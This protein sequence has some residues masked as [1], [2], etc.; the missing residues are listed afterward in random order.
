MKEIASDEMPK[1][2]KEGA[3]EMLKA[4]DLISTFIE[5]LKKSLK[6]DELDEVGSAI[7]KVMAIKCCLN[8]YPTHRE[9]IVKDFEKQGLIKILN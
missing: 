8:E 3:N 1:E 5:E 9:F 4:L 6:T 2:I 7:I